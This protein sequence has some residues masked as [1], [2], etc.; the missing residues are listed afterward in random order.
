MR[1]RFIYSDAHYDCKLTLYEFGI[2][3]MLFNRLIL[4]WW[5]EKGYHW[6]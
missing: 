2:S 1:G 5:V 3:K 6:V 4:P